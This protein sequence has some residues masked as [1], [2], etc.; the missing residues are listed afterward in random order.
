[1]IS[2]EFD[3]GCLETIFFSC[4][5]QSPTELHSKNKLTRTHQFRFFCFDWLGWRWMR[6]PL[7]GSGKI[8]SNTVVLTTQKLL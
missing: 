5:R 6:C 8:E 3:T 4:N 7:T 1:M 2:V